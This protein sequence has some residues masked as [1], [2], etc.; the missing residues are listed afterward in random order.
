MNR[1]SSCRASASSAPWWPRAGV[2]RTPTA[3]GMMMRRRRSTASSSGSRIQL[4]RPASRSEAG[5][6][7]GSTLAEGSW[8]MPSRPFRELSH[9][10]LV[11]LRQRVTLFTLRPRRS[12]MPLKIMP[13]GRLQ[14]WVAEEKGYFAAEGLEY[15]FV[16]DSGDYG[17]QAI[18]RDD[19]GDVRTGAF[20]TFGTGR[21]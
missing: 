5:S 15:T 1:V 11:T 12:R 2:P 17:I 21:D 9:P 14:D 13:H 3:G 4:S 6:S 10:P 20:E 7:C 8:A 19:A 16:T 18:E